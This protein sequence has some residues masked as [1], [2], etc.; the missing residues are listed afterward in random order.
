M[1]NKI[2][3]TDFWM[4]NHVPLS[5]LGQSWEYIPLTKEYH[6]IAVDGSLLVDSACIVQHEE[7][8][9]L[10]CDLYLAAFSYL[11]GFTE[12]WGQ[13]KREQSYSY[14][15]RMGVPNECFEYAWV[16]RILLL[17]RRLDAK[18]RNVDEAMLFGPIPRATIRLEHDVDALDKTLQIRL[19]QSLFEL[20]W[21]LTHIFNLDWLSAKAS[22]KRSYRMIFSSP[23]YFHLDKTAEM[24]TQH[25]VT[26][27]YYIHARKRFRG[28][29]SWLVDPSYFCSD[30]RLQNFVKKRLHQGFRFALHPSFH[31]FDDP[32]KIGR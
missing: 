14:A 29:I 19:K 12:K 7:R 22:I 17:L 1:K 32:K 24:A 8:P 30:E 23:T 25:G 6:D 11:A 31:S 26:A 5:R 9:L 3:P 28:P 16:N 13:E 10:G 27:T 18:H 4:D 2:G 21:L 15:F 20:F